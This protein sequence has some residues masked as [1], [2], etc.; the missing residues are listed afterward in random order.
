MEW[1][2]LTGWVRSRFQ[3]LLRGSSARPS[4]HTL[5]GRDPL[6]AGLQ[7]CHKG[8][9][10][11]AGCQEDSVQIAPI[12]EFGLAD[13]VPGDVCLDLRMGSSRRI[14]AWGV[15][16]SLFGLLIAIGVIFWVLVESAASR[17]WA[18]F[19]SDVKG[20]LDQANARSPGRPVL[21][22][23][24]L[25]GNAWEDYAQALRQID[26]D[27]HSVEIL[28]DWLEARKSSSGEQLTR[29]F[30]TNRE[31]LLTIRL[32]AQRSEAGFPHQWDQE[33]E[34]R[35]GPSIKSLKAAIALGVIE[36]QK[37]AE[38][39]N[40]R[41]SA[42][43]LLD[44]C[45]VARDFGH[46]RT[47][48]AVLGSVVILDVLLEDVRKLLLS[49]GMGHDLIASM[50]QELRVLNECFPELEFALLNDALAVGMFFRNIPNEP[51]SEMDIRDASLADW[52]Y[53][54]SWRI[55][56]ASALLE[57]SNRLARAS[58]ACKKPWSEAKQVALELGRDL[59]NCRNE[60]GRLIGHSAWTS[61]ER[62]R[63]CKARLR[64]LIAT[65]EFL[66][67]GTLPDLED[68]FGTRLA[69]RR[70]TGKLRVWSVGPDGIDNGGVGA[71]KPDDAGLDIVLEAGR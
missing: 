56:I 58:E 21:R 48:L 54:F 62:V 10:R 57:H 22:G 50:A 68:P 19:E 32:G 36:A 31:V 34:S 30:A 65:A 29:I 40:S 1:R 13:A 55:E 67:K 7:G 25:R 53:G 5:T 64:L 20:L 70:S 49:D 28:S 6:E 3:D 15:Y 61:L 11:R 14:P 12:P 39:G 42:E 69:H 16:A 41:G 4:G 33:W 60:L 37:L 35:T 26:S 44:L 52:R 27:S 38:S 66:S 45:M 46:N 8:Q 9:E 18:R 2:T 51:R 17:E 71:W 59:A 43:L 24:S 23:Q 47:F 63:A